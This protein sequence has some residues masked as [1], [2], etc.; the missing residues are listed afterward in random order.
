MNIIGKIILIFIVFWGGFFLFYK[1]VLAASYQDVVF[2]EIMWSG[3]NISSSDEW[4]ELY[5]NTDSNIDLSNWQIT[6]L[7][8][9]VETLM[10]TIPT[11]IIPSHG[12]YLISNNAK[13][14]IF[15]KGES[16]I[17]V[18]PDLIESSLT[19]SNTNLLL[20]LY[21]G[22]YLNSDIMDHANDGTSPFAGN[23]DTKISMERVYPI[24]KGELAESWKN[25]T[26]KENL[27]NNATDIANPHNSGRPSI[28]QPTDDL[29]AY[30]T[31]NNHTTIKFTT[32][33]DD[34]D[35]LS[36]I[37]EVTIDLSNL[38][39]ANIQKLF[40]DGT[41]GDS[42]IG[43]GI[44]SLD[45]TLLLNDPTKQI[46]IKDIVIK[47]I[48]SK[49]LVALITQKINLFQLSNDLII[50][51]ILPYPSTNTN[52]EF[53]ELYNRSQNPINLLNWQID[54]MANAGSSPY[55][56]N[57]QLI[58]QPNSYIVF[59]K[60]TIGIILNNDKD[61]VRLIDPNGQEKSVVHYYLVPESGWAYNFNNNGWY[62][63]NNSSKNLA[64][65][66]K[67]NTIQPTAN[68]IDIKYI[69]SQQENTKPKNKINLVNKSKEITSKVQPQNIT[70]N[71][72]AS[73]FDF[74]SNQTSNSQ[75]LWINKTEYAILFTIIL[76][77]ILL[78]RIVYVKDQKINL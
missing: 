62:W 63:T 72:A 25:A 78:I 27:D 58:I 24:A 57:S 35:G 70:T 69:I 76:S 26:V 33:V 60:S 42:M 45:Y 18:D 32:K 64:N 23:N 12:Y 73:V 44:Y 6:Y 49:G 39:Q 34:P 22:S 7:K 17:N 40:D 31:Y 51:E 20:K 50:N 66:P 16:V 3:S 52:D 13:D 56:I 30:L 11:G 46:G 8:N 19:L 14:H 65:N 29:K 53:I 74:S 38:G 1:K 68:N 10:L 21:N 36:D 41:N 9:G 55:L 77:V 48:D 67:D 28:K 15:S 2:S 37:K 47:A 61:Q 43:D 54:D 59:N 75:K 5:N 71:V 4:I